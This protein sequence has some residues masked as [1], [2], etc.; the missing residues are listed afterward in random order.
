MVAPNGSPTDSDASCLD[1]ESIP[2]THVSPM[3]KQLLYDLATLVPF[4]G[5][6]PTH[7]S[8]TKYRFPIW[9]FGLYSFLYGFVSNGNFS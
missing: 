1:T 7:R 4:Q 6:V 3:I 5:P 2:E 8:V 9:I